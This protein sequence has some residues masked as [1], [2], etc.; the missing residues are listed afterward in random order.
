MRRGGQAFG[1]MQVP[2]VLVL[3]LA[4]LARRHARLMR[5]QARHLGAHQGAIDEVEAEHKQTGVVAGLLQIGVEEAKSEPR[6]LVIEQVHHQKRDLVH[7]VDPAKVGIELDAVEGRGHAFEQRDVSQVQVAVA[8]AHPAVALAR[9]EHG[10]ERGV[11]ARGPVAQ[12]REQRDIRFGACERQHLLEVLQRGREYAR[13]AS[14]RLL[15]SGA[16]DLRVERG[17]TAGERID[18]RRQERPAPRHPVEQIVLV[19]A[20]HAQRILD[21]RSAAA[22]HRR[23]RAAAD[24]DHVQIESGRGAAVQ[25]QFLFAKVTA[26]GECA[27]IQKTE[28]HR[29]LDLIG[30]VAGKQDAGDVGLQQFDA[31]DRMAI[32]RRFAQGRDQPVEV[33]G[34]GAG[35]LRRIVVAGWVHGEFRTCVP[36]QQ[37]TPLLRRAIEQ[38]QAFANALPTNVAYCALRSG[39]WQRQ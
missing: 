2:P 33:R 38:Y 8:L 3:D 37:V 5:A 35:L 6:Q 15:G 39:W 34:G 11:L 22:D 7:D 25:A 4:L 31:L 28:I 18:V 20:A 24:R 30:I 36:K 29:L 21:R 23:R 1:Q 19:E 17:Q 12:P 13:R 32:A 27:E 26:R 16:L 9:A 10:G 14:E